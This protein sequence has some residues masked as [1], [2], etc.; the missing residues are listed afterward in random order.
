[1][2]SLTVNASSKYDIT[3]TDTIR[4]FREKCVPY[5][6]GKNVAVVTDS[7]VN[8]L[9]GDALSEYLSDKTVLKIVI[10]AGEDSKNGENYF[11]ILNALAENGF[12]REDSIVAFGG[13]VVGDLAGFAA[14]TYMRGI[15]LIALPTTILSMVDSSVGGKTA[16]DLPAGKNLCGTFYQPT[17]VYINT[18]FIETL[19]RRE[20]MCGAGEI[21]KYALLSDTVKAEDLKAGV[22]E[23]LIVKCLEIKRDIVEK[24]EKERGERALLNL[25]HTVGHALEKLYGYR[26]SHGE[27]VVKGLAF[28]VFA[29]EKL[30]GLN[31]KTVSEMERTVNFFGHDVSAGFSAEEI[32]KLIVSDK[33]RYG[34][35]VNFIALKGVGEPRVE[36]ISLNALYELLGEYE[37][38]NNTL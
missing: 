17:A 5:M 21:L 19:P 30:Y 22:N 14:S 9:Y 3:V 37:R 35:N 8:A 26:V 31:K 36:K 6:R 29:S 13:G 11:K 23:K 32:A 15:T 10:P 18:A 33:K 25:G 4:A 38:K 16:I 24:D 27:C 1:M 7:N 20:F 34:E 12:D 28:S 2:L